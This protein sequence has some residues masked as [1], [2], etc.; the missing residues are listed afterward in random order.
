[1]EESS[2]EEDDYLEWV[3]EKDFVDALEEGGW[4]TLKGDKIKKGWPDRFCFGPR[5]H[6]GRTVI[7]EFK[8]KGAKKRRGE[9]LQDHWRGV[10]EKMGFTVHKITGVAEANELRDYL[11]A[12]PKPMTYCPHG[13]PHRYACWECGG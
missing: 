7:V 1:M 12:V 8:K 4:E 10:F 6:G 13:I 5:E 2:I 9:K 3:V 11:L